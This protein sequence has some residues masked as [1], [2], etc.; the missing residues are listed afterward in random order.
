[1]GKGLGKKEMN[2]T[3][4]SQEWPLLYTT[5]GESDFYSTSKAGITNLST[6]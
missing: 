1:L 6:Y 3:L 5:S 2:P 4:F